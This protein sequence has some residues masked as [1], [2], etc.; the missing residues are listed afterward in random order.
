MLK[1][2]PTVKFRLKVLI[3]KDAKIAKLSQLIK[4]SR[5]DLKSLKM[6]SENLKEQLNLICDKS[7]KENVHSTMN[8]SKH[9]KLY[10]ENQILNKENVKYQHKLGRAMRAIENYQEEINKS[11]FEVDLYKN[12]VDRLT[13]LTQ[14]QEKVMAFASHPHQS[15]Y[16]VI[17]AS[18]GTVQSM[19]N[20]EQ[21]YPGETEEEEDEDEEE[22]AYQDEAT[23]SDPGYQYYQRV[24]KSY[25]PAYE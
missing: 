18:P 7:D 22:N 17:H 11:T 23:F 19:V 24:P 16:S 20:V 9:K 13:N 1:N 2:Y 25:I 5:K 12:Q 8:K 14:S 15:N 4:N 3:N 10:Y 6:I 21:E